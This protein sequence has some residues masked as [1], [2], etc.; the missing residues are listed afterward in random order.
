[1]S[2]GKISSQAQ[3]SK[4]SSK[5]ARK[6]AQN[7][8]SQ[9]CRRERDSAKAWYLQNSLAAIQSAS[10]LNNKDQ[11]SVLLQAYL[12]LIDENE[13]LRETV[14]GFRKRFLSLSNAAATAAGDYLSKMSKR[15]Y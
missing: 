1:M 10:S 15:S 4:P 2:D 6:R 14:L 11:Y 7:R 9:Q 5:N 3:S 8:I 12:E 13:S